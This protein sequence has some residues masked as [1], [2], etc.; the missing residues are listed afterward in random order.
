MM[1]RDLTE[2]SDVVIAVEDSVAGCLLV[3][4]WL[5]KLSKYYGDMSRSYGPIFSLMKAS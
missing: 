2:S 5:S 1:T 3:V 4:V